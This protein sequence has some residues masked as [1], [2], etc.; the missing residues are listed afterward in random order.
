MLKITKST[1]VS[2]L[3]MNIWVVQGIDVG[4]FLLVQLDYQLNLFQI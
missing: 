4:L 2:F 1:L 3:E